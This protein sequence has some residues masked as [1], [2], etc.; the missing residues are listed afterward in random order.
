MHAKRQNA[1]ILWGGVALV[2]AV[3]TAMAYGPTGSPAGGFEGGGEPAAAG[4]AAPAP[5]ETPAAASVT[6]TENRFTPATVTIQ[7]GGT[8]T[9]RNTSSVVHTV[10]GSGF[11]SGNLSPGATFQR[12]FTAAGRYPYWCIPHQKAGMTGTV[13]VK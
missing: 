11:N 10:T 9:W 2:G 13:V 3:A 6:M 4:V 12:T 5:A 7:R 8:V 1:R